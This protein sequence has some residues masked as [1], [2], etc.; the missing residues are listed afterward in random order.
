MRLVDHAES[1]DGALGAVPGIELVLLHP[2][3]VESGDID[4]RAAIDNPLGHDATH[5]ATGE[6]AHRVHAGRN[7]VVVDPRRLAHDRREV[8]SE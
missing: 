1:L 7:E 5:A 4:I 3:D 2:I 6:D 8:G